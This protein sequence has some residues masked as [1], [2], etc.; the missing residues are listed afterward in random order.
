MKKNERRR[1]KVLKHLI[2]EYIFN[3]EAV[4]SRQLFENHFSSVSP[5]TLRIDLHKLEEDGQIFQPHTSAGRIPTIKGYRS[6]LELAGEEIANIEYPRANFLRELLIQN[7]KDTPLAMH[8][9]KQLLAKETDQV[10]FVAEPE[11]AYGYLKKLDVFKIGSHKLLFVVSLDSGLDKTVIIKCDYDISEQQLKALVRYVNEELYGLRIYDIQ[12]K[13]KSITTKETSNNRLF[14]MFLHE[15]RNA[16]SEISNFF[17][18]F[19]GGT[20]FLNQPEFDTKEKIVTFFGLMQRHDVLASLLQKHKNDKPYTVIMGEEFGN[21]LWAEF[22]LIFA[23]YELFEVPG[24]L[25]V[26]APL[27]ADYKKNIPIIRDIANTITETTKKGM[28]VSY[29]N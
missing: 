22:V 4:S 2:E 10:S 9:I 17:I 8:Y 27:R 15:L 18:H 24:C 12:A 16:F 6:Y 11:I 28:M 7:Y 25:G 19:E 5:A 3:A 23:R 21:P 26:L 20:N 14:E 1:L 29:E 13:L